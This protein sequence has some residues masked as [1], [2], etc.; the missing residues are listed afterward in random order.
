MKG[1]ITRER[2]GAEGFGYDPIFRPEG[3]KHTFAEM[4]A[5]QKNGISHRGRATAKLAE[6]LLK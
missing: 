4:T 1:E 6:Y 3:F 2:S 5:E